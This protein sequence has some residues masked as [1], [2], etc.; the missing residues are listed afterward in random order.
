MARPKSTKKGSTTAATRK[1]TQ[2]TTSKQRHKQQ[3]DNDGNSDNEDRTPTKNTAQ[4]TTATGKASKRRRT[5]YH[6]ETSENPSD[7][8]EERTPPSRKRQKKKAVSNEDSDSDIVQDVSM[9]PSAPAASIEVEKGTNEVLENILQCYEILIR[10]Q[11]LHKKHEIAIPNPV[12]VQEEAADIPLL[13]S[14]LCNVSFMK[15]G[16]S[17]VER[18]RWCLVCKCVIIHNYQNTRFTYRNIRVDDKFIA[19]KGLR[20]AFF[21]GGNSACR[22]HVH[23]HYDLYAKKCLE[24]GIPEHH[25][26]VPPKIARARALEANAAARHSNP[27]QKHGFETIPVT[28]GPAE[29]SKVHILEHTAKYIICNDQVSMLSR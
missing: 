17:T 25:R 21:T 16:V 7:D 14:E 26:A 20:G 9:T 4:K 1:T 13:F 22:G 6:E 5:R 23:K 3:V 19:R 28:G 2:K 27:F 29:F 24:K 10:C 8:D 18:G 11:I 12:N 15:N